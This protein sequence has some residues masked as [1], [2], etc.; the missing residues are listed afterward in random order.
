MRQFR[1]IS[2]AMSAYDGGGDGQGTGFMKPR[3]PSSLPVAACVCALA[4]LLCAAAPAAAQNYEMQQLLN[5]MERL[6]QEMSTLQRHV[7]RGEKPPPSAV[8][9]APAGGDA[10][11]RT[12]VARLSQRVNELE[13]ELRR[14]TGRN[15]E[16]GHAVAQVKSRLDKLVA[17]VDFRLTA[18]ERGAPAA[19]APGAPPPPQSDAAPIGGETGGDSA[20]GA[21]AAPGPNTLGTLRT[22]PAG[23]PLPSAPGAAPPAQQQAAVP[24]A[25]T[26]QQ[27]YDRAH[28][29]IVKEQNFTEAERVLRD[30]IDRNPKHDLTPN[31]HYWLGRTYFV[32]EDFQQA[33]F[34]FAEGVQKFPRSEKAP[35]NL[36]NLGMSLA[37]LGK[38]REACTAYSR[39]L[40][41]FPDAEESVKRRVP[42]EQAR[43]KCR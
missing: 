29:L 14:M 42:R 19:A 35:A 10:A 20:S 22:D 31:A 11:S 41:N 6:Q 8:A 24:A 21:P 30:F 33:A 40:Q 27:Q 37:R 2:A 16:L 23:R 15:E 5:R 1:R 17:D 12:L 25:E 18:L 13:G 4:A 7:Y 43:A 36:L 3:F 9:P 38:E 39:L 34:T 32:R 28:T 26:P